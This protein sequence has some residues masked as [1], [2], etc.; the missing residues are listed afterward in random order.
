MNYD[1]CILLFLLAAFGIAADRQEPVY[2]PWVIEGLRVEPAGGMKVRVTAGVAELAGRR[3]TF[4]ETILEIAPPPTISVA[5]EKLVP[6]EEKPQ[7]W[8]AGTSL[9]ECTCFPNGAGTPLPYCLQPHS[10][11]VKKGPGDA[12]TYEEGR[13]FLI[14]HDW[15]KLGRIADGRIQQGQEVFV[16]YVYRLAR[17]DS[18]V[19]TRSGRIT[20]V[21]GPARKTCPPPP[22]LDHGDA[23]L[24]NLLVWYDTTE[25]KPGLIFPCGPSYPE[26]SDAERLER[27]KTV[28]HTLAKLRAGEEVVVCTWGDSVTAGGDAIPTEMAFP[29]AFARALRE[30]YPQARVK[31]VNA[32]IGGTNTVRRLP[33]LDAEVLAH[34]PD[35]VTIEFVNDCY[36]PAETLL[37][38]WR[39]A[40]G[41]IKA[42][43]ADVIVIT[44]HF[45]MP[46]WMGWTYDDMWGRDNRPAVELMRQ[47]AR[48]TGAGL[49]DASRRWEHLCQEGLPYVT[50]LWNGINHPDNRGHEL[51]VRELMTFF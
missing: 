42:T 19:L 24:A 30:K 51:F 46:P 18:V 10:V 27:Q 43:G 44:P 47:V 2:P 31:L 13:D 4:P 22:E 33:N 39:E 17:L 23:R 35:L 21:R 41:R 50:L 1:Y 5:D 26:P 12:P 45:V 36:I 25:I 7:S 16:D 32:G 15:A 37:A 14:D 48:E 6:A 9:R 38:N 11:R 40:I 3:I 28:A 49:A 29:W 20:L 8:S 34:H